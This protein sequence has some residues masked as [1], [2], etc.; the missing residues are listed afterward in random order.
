MGCIVQSSLKHLAGSLAKLV[1]ALTPLGG[2]SRHPLPSGGAEHQ[3]RGVVVLL[4]RLEQGAGEVGL[5]R[6]SSTS[7][8]VRAHRGT[9]KGR[10]GTA[11]S[12]Q[13]ARASLSRLLGHFQ[14][15]CLTARCMLSGRV[16]PLTEPKD[17]VRAPWGLLLGKL[18]HV[19]PVPVALADPCLRPQGAVTCACLG[20]GVYKA[21]PH[22]MDSVRIF[23]TPEI[24]VVVVAWSPATGPKQLPGVREQFT[25]LTASGQFW[26]SRQK[27]EC[28]GYAVLPLPFRE[29]S[30]LFPV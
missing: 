11:A 16:L 2:R 6:G 17:E 4:A 29:P 12:P 13:P 25:L 14:Q 20:S 15:Q 19:G 22:Q 21:S 1:E 23:N 26:V 24:W 30:R 5:G 28:L 8:T 3:P 9:R 27:A 7:T 18:G 10:E